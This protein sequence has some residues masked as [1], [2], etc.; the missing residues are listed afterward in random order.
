MKSA[1]VIELS[2][3]RAGVKVQIEWLNGVAADVGA[4]PL[5]ASAFLVAFHLNRYGA[6]GAREAWPSQETLAAD[7]GFSARTVRTLIDDLVTR[8]HL[9][10]VPGR[11]RNTTSCYRLL[12][13][14][15]ASAN[16]EDKPEAGFRLTGSKSGS[17]LPQLPVE[18]RKSDALKAEILRNKSGSPLPTEGSSEGSSEGEREIRR[19][20][21]TEWPEGKS[22][23]PEWIEDAQTLIAS[24]GIKA[25]L[26][27][28]AGA[29][30]DWNL[31]KGRKCRNW[32]AAWRNWIRKVRNVDAASV[33]TG[34]R[35]D[36]KIW[37]GVGWVRPMGSA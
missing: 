34:A 5:G 25:D 36:G 27:R 35:A 23:P 16:T 3:R 9:E 8:G 33:A 20:R 13:R 6:N 10:V 24:L 7:T 1:E 17:L 28:E 12:N 37:D 22:V 18:K 30:V 4:G 31:S 19:S 14:K 2:E 26:N 29:F 32:R 11:G 21:E 15:S